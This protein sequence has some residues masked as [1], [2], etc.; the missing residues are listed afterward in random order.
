[1]ALLVVSVVII[2]I[3]RFFDS[4]RTVYV[5][6]LNLTEMQQSARGSQREIKALGRMLGRGGIPAASDLRPLPKGI[7]IEILNNVDSDTRI[8]ED[9]TDS[10]VPKVLENTDVLVLR[11]A[12]NSPIFQLNHANP[13]TFVR[14]IT[15]PLAGDLLL[16]NTTPTG[17][18]QSL[19]ELID[20]V[21]LSKANDAAADK[22]AIQEAILLTS[23]FDSSIYGIAELDA[24]NSDVSDPT[25]IR[26]RVLL[27]D[28]TK[29]ERLANAY[30]ELCPGGI[31]PTVLFQSRVGFVGVL[32]EYR[33]YIREDYRISN[34]VGNDLAPRLSRA[35]VYPDTEIAY[36][37][38]LEELEEDVAEYTFDLQV[39]LGFDSTNGGTWDDDIDGVGIDDK[40]YETQ[41]GDGDDWLYNSAADQ[42]TQPPWDN[43]PVTNDIEPILY[44]L[45]VT[46]LNRTRNPDRGVKAPVIAAIEDRDYSLDPLND[47]YARRYRRLILQT[48]IDM[49]NLG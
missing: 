40:I 20:L 31:F 14:T 25:Q 41:S 18:P 37:K 17:V 33:F 45:R 9:S 15:D 29:P 4:T 26:L 6:Q 46:T 44:Y 24:V 12:F 13:N 7:S 28:P 8:L 35:R 34:G 47:F 10:A 49:R 1:M 22:E 43:R 2:A 27:P 32:E 21:N 19:Q 36:N 39:A 11:G 23:P 42:D 48:V 38:D 30:E 3:S 5:G 16:S